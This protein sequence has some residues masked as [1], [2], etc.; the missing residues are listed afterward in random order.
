MGY[1]N[2]KKRLYSREFLGVVLVKLNASPRNAV[3]VVSGPFYTAAL[4]PNGRVAVDSSEAFE[5]RW[6]VSSQVALA[7]SLVALGALERARYTDFRGQ[8]AEQKVLRQ[9]GYAA[10]ELKDAAE[11]L[12]IDLTAEQHRVIEDLTKAD[13]D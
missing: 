13:E 9:R 8:M 5:E 4:L 7:K 6:G 3:R 11:R 10:R 2:R 12:G 1:Y